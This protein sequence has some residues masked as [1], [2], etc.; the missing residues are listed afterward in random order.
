MEMAGSDR[1]KARSCGLALIFTS[2]L[3]ALSASAAEPSKAERAWLPDQGDGSYRNPVLAGDYS[4]PDVVR[5]GE[6]Y[7][8]VASS[9]TNVPGLPIL[10]STDLVNWTIIGHALATI[11]PEAHHA[12][13][14]RGGGVWAP[15]IRHRDGKFLIYYPDPDFGV[16]V[17][18][19]KDPAGP[20]SKPALVDDRKGIIDPAPF[21]DDDGQGWLVNGWAKSRAGFANVITAKRLNKAGDR[22]VG[23]PI[24]LIDGQR[25]PKVATSIGPF[26]WMT[27]EGPKLYKRDGWYYVF[28]PSGSVK[29]GWQGVFRSRK[30]EGP[31]EG[32]N[33]LDQ[34]RTPINGPHQGAWVTTPTGEDWFLHFQDTDSYGRRVWLE[35]MA[36]KDGWPVI[37]QDPDG[38][39]IGEPVLVHRK[40]ATKV[41]SPRQ[42]PQD[43][44][45]FDGK[46]S[47]AWQWNSNPQMDWA[48]L[49]ARPGFARLKS[50]SSSE[51]L[52]ESGALLTQK[53]PA[54]HFTITTKLS[55]APKAVGERAG[56]LMFGADYAWIGLQ[57]GPSG[58]SLVRVDRTGADKFKPERVETALAQAPGTVWLRMSAEPVVETDPAP[59]FSP[60]WPSMLRSTHA[61]VTLSYSLDGE[62]FTVVGSPFVSRPGRWVG[63]QVGLFAQAP[64]GT[65]SNTATRIGW[66]DFDGFWVSR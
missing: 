3:M 16:F 46:L 38:D 7:Y 1:S 47:L 25:L 54:E 39:G 55:F 9:F 43:T 26:P 57:N 48:D 45:D 14:R 31:Y 21:W 2:T 60:Y 42:A 59:D 30:L 8:L 50:I 11:P 37:G 62:T 53:L 34:G 6:A 36:W 64:A 56:L 63:A 58:P 24:T 41:P 49:K 19:A 23:E 27:T 35:P 10:R 28:A 17:V 61:R 66:T 52:W 13:P 22:A 51:N 15:A 40:P 4:D 44:D 65:P 33:V 12:T 32:R 20:W 29:G 5:V 18:S